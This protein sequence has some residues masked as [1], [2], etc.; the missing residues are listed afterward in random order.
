M[1]NI[2][3]VTNSKLCTI[4]FLSQIEKICQSNIFKIILREKHLTQDEYFSLALKV[5]EIT[6]KNNISLT[7]HNFPEV[8][9]KLG[10]KSVH[11]PID[12]LKNTDISNFVDIGTSV[13]S[14]EQAKL[15]VNL[16]ATYLTAGHIFETDC[17]KG[18]AP[19]GIDL[20]KDI[21]SQINIP[22][23]AIG[24]INANNISKLHNCHI[25]GVCIM[26]SLMKDK[27]PSKTVEILKNS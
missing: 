13:H 27:N 23:Y 22:V 24:G 18:L 10:I 9:L 17:K 12:I 16:G 3:C 5:K 6:D 11:L 20:L 14:T 15:A 19:K 21:T 8:A 7:V 4:D 25:N 1:F 2:I 26:S